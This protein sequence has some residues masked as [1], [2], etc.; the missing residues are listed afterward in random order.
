MRSHDLSSRPIILLT[1]LF[2]MHATPCLCELTGPRSK[3]KKLTPGG[4]FGIKTG[5]KKKIIDASAPARPPTRPPVPG[6][7]IDEKK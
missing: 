3:E 7:G 1:R 4:H 5:E 6:A 2:L